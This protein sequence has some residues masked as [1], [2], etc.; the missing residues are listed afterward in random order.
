MSKPE[1]TPTRPIVSR[2]RAKR[3][4]AKRYFTGEPCQHGHI[5]ERYVKRAWC[6]EC[7]RLGMKPEP[8]APKRYFAAKPCK[9]GHFERYVVSGNCVECNK[10][11]SKKWQAADSARKA[12]DYA[13]IRGPQQ[14]LADAKQGSNQPDPDF[15]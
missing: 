6:V 5:C 15:C 14:R 10:E 3:W 13:R 12:A 4:G 1:A 8:R 2:E 7:A 11:Q 9:R